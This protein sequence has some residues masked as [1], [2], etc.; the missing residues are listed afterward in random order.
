MDISS[1]GANREKPI[2]YVNSANKSNFANFKLSIEWCHLYRALEWN[3]QFF[4]LYLPCKWAINVLNS[5]WP[6]EWTKL[7]SLKSRIRVYDLL[8]YN[9]PSEWTMFF[10][11]LKS[12]IGVYDLFGK[13]VCF[14]VF[15]KITG[16]RCAKVYNLYE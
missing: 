13:R 9:W 6:S 3:I 4:V 2:L 16:K 1:N 7:F 14:L 11:N 8:N 12:H 10:F 15:V 5:I